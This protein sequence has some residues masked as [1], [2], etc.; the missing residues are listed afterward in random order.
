MK[1]RHINEHSPIWNRMT[2]LSILG[3]HCSSAAAYELILQYKQQTKH[4]IYMVFKHQVD[5]QK[6]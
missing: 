3:G 6:V 5:D 1:R 2:P 4:T